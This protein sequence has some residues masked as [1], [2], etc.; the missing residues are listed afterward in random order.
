MIS[1][2]P[3]PSGEAM[4]TSA[5]AWLAR[6]QNRL[7]RSRAPSRP[8]SIIPDARR[9]ALTAPALEPLTASK[10]I[11]A[12][13]SNRSRTPQVNAPNDPPPCSARLSVS[14]GQG[15]GR[16]ARRRRAGFRRAIPSSGLIASA[17]AGLGGA[18]GTPAGRRLGSTAL[19]SGSTSPGTVANASGGPSA[20]DFKS[21]RASLAERMSFWRG[22]TGGRS[23]V[24]PSATGSARVSSAGSGA[25]RPRVALRNVA[26][27]F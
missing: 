18:A 6:F 21:V 9:T 27:A 19:A 22:S 13:S 14:G 26:S 12:S 7:R 25:K 11:W 24:D 2:R 10:S 16:L 5:A 20:G 4:G 23:V 3:A 8:P 17:T 15:A 1:S